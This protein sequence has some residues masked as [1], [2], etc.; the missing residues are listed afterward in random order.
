M[1]LYD[2]IT[3]YSVVIKYK[4]LLQYNFKVST[5]GFNKKKDQINK[6]IIKT[7]IVFL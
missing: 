4:I 5:S 6:L 3:E 1:D 7:R 2:I